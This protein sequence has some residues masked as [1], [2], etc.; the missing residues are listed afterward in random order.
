MQQQA[1]VT[2]CPKCS[3]PSRQPLVPH[4]DALSWVTALQLSVHC[5][6]EL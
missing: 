1:E 3:L 4:P 2:L 5:F 6:A